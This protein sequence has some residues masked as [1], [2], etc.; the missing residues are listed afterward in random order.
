MGYGARALQA[1]NSYYSGE[2]FSL[3]ESM[4]EDQSYPDAAAFDPVSCL[5][6]SSFGQADV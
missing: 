2:Y 3:D 4:R 1:L 5:S 6:V